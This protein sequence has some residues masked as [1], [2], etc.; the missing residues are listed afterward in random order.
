[1]LSSSLDRALDVAATLELRGFAEARRA[2]R[3]EIPWSRHD[4]AFAAS[5]AAVVALAVWARL[6]G[7]ASFDAYPEIKG[8]SAGETIALGTAL[9]I[10]M[11]APFAD[12]RGVEP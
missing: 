7:I 11:L 5:A 3:K 10:A 9:A 6:A 8:A 12:R 1:M 4:L 2:Q